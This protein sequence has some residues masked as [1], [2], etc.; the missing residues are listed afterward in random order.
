MTIPK[1][2]IHKIKSL[3]KHH[4]IVAIVATLAVGMV[5]TSGIFYFKAK[6]IQS[7]AN[8]QEEL[9]K[10]TKKLTDKISKFYELPK[11]EIPTVAT[12]SEPEKVKDQVFFRDTQKDDKVLFYKTGK[13]AILYRPSTNKIIAVSTLDPSTPNQS[14]S[15]KT[16]TTE[17]KNQTGTI[18]IYNSTKTA[19]LAKKYESLLKEKFPSIE[20]TSTGNSQIDQV[21][22]TIIVDL[23][24]SKKSDA[25]II[26]KEMQIDQSTLPA[27]E[28]KPDADFLIIL[29]TDKVNL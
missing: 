17:P 22:K 5:V 7:Q 26:A 10:A 3:P 23:G 16:I 11:D 29:G 1:L 9:E 12:V 21:E 28:A 13:K 19:G 15:Q 2:P 6:N 24:G 14:E 4:L 25:D 8:R 18:A 27:G 20:I